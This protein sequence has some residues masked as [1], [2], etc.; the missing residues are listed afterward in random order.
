MLLSVR[1]KV[2]APFAESEVPDSIICRRFSGHQKGKGCSAH[3]AAA[4]E[5]LTTP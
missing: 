2:L 5:V 4:M 1:L 3:G